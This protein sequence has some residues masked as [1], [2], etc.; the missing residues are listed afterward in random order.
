MFLR[1]EPTATC[2]DIDDDAPATKLV[3]C[4]AFALP[5]AADSVTNSG[6]GGKDA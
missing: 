3:D 1:N 4:P 2:K 6:T 5:D